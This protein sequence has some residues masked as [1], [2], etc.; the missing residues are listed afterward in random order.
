MPT[1]DTLWY[2]LI[3]KTDQGATGDFAYCNFSEA[4]GA[5]AETCCNHQESVS[6]RNIIF[7]NNISAL[8]GYNGY[9]S[10]VDSCEFYNNLVAIRNA[11]KNIKNSVFLNNE[12]G[13]FKTERINIDSSYFAQNETAIYG[14]RG[15]LSNTVI[16][17]NIIGIRSNYEG[18]NIQECK[19]LNNDIGV[20]LG[21]YD[22]YYPPTKYN[23]ICYNR[24]Y[25]VENLDDIN[26]DLTKNCW[27]TSD[28]VEIE[29]KLYDGYDNIFIGLLNYSIYD[30]NCVNELRQVI[31]IVLRVEDYHEIPESFSLSQNYPNPFN[32]TTTIKFTISD[33]RFAILKVY[34]VLGNE[35]ATLINEELPAG[36]YEVEFNPASSIRYPA[37]GIYFY[38]LR[39][40]NFIE[41]KK[42]LLIK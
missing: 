38:Q 26:K 7:K 15:Y 3:I 14:G 42:M 22:N 41:T 6:Y 8:T 39:V 12:Y 28:S 35:I 31:K 34:D 9:K 20:Q 37:S 11:D 18:F 5:I 10:V 1:N 36:E 21:S 24:I 40:G 25:N 23:E 32:P 16:E 2:G 29:S 30:S 19:I 27:C 17:N 4:S 33:L 13:L